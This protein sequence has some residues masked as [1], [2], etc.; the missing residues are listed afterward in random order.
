LLS[1]GVASV[2]VLS[3]ARASLSVA[4]R[5]PRVRRVSSDGEIMSTAIGSI[6]GVLSSGVD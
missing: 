6:T 1:F 2:S 5:L 3:W 4:E